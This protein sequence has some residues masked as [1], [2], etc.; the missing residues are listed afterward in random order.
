MTSQKYKVFDY[1]NSLSQGQN[2]VYADLKILMDAEVGFD[3]PLTIGKDSGYLDQAELDIE[4]LTT[5]IAIYG[6]SENT[7]G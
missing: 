6:G 1:L 7:P 5:E 3:N 4:I 2:V